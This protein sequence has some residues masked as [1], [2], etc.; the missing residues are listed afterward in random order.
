MEQ[1]SIS[2]ILKQEPCENKSI[3]SDGKQ[4]HT[5][6]YLYNCC[7][8]GFKP[9]GTDNYGCGCPY[10]FDCNACAHCLNE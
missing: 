2:E 3:S 9:D 4:I 8:C 7:S 6:S 1:L 10:C 5:C